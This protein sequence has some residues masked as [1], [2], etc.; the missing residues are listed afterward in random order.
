MIPYFKLIRWGNLLMMAILLYLLRYALALPLLESA[1]KA[2]LMTDL[3]FSVMVL[4]CILVAAGGYVIND[5]ED[6]AMDIRNK[7]GKRI[8]EVDISRDRAFNFYMILSFTGI[9]CGIW[10]TYVKDYPYIAMINILSTGLLY[11]YSTSYKCIPLLGN[12]VIA[13]LSALLV[14]LVVLPEPLAKADPGVMLMTGAYMYF[15]FWMTL[16]REMIKDIEDLE[17]DLAEGCI[18][19]AGRFG[20]VTSRNICLLIILLITGSL[21]TAQY[22]SQQWEALFPFIYVTLFI[23]LPLLGLLIHLMRATSKSDYTSASRWVKLIT[24]AG[25]ISLAVFYYSFNQTDV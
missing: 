5:L 11:F 17:G 10:L 15:S 14:F 20:T 9:L 22:V 3:E 23:D 6:S 18:T 24:F 16:L 7:P 19:F 4:G 21:M 8:A 12:L 13:L 2:L 1:G 25:I